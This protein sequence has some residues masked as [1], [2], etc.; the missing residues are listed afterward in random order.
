MIRPPPPDYC[1]RQEPISSTSPAESSHPGAVRLKLS[2]YTLN[3]CSASCNWDPDTLALPH[4]DHHAR[5][6]APARRHPDPERFNRCPRDCPPAKIGPIRDLC[7]HQRDFSRH[8]HYCPQAAHSSTAKSRDHAADAANRIQRLGQ[9]AH[10][11]HDKACRRNHPDRELSR[12]SPVTPQNNLPIWDEM[13]AVV[14]R[15]VAEHQPS[16]I[17]RHD[18]ARRRQFGLLAVSRDTPSSCCVG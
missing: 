9:K 3:I 12:R 11:D 4:I 13:A 7:G 18:L 17:T 5:P 14:N 16:K 15:A 1:S 8:P 2:K 6:T 10:S